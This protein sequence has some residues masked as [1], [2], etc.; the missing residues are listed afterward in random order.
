MGIF[1]N[2]QLIFL[3]SI[4]FF[5]E[6]IRLS[7]KIALDCIGALQFGQFLYTHKIGSVVKNGD[8]NVGRN[9]ISVDFASA[10]AA[11]EFL[12]KPE[13][14]MCKFKSSVPIYNSKGSSEGY[15]G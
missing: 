15:S 8:K 13:V 9:K 1:I 5:R 14:K 2:T 4:S 10:Q 3:I 11:N 6:K 7:K 12:K